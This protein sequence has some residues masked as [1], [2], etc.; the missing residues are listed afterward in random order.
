M[1][2]GERSSAVEVNRAIRSMGRRAGFERDLTKE[3]IRA[4]RGRFDV[5]LDRWRQ[6]K[7]SEVLQLELEVLP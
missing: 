1:I 5:A 3:E 6:T 7:R 4:I 2:G